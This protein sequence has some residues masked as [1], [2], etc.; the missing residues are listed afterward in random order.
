LFIVVREPKQIAYANVILTAILC[1][2]QK[3][4]T[5]LDN[6]SVP[7]PQVPDDPS[8]HPYFWIV[9]ALLQEVVAVKQVTR[10]DPDQ[11]MISSYMGLSIILDED[12]AA[13]TFVNLISAIITSALRSNRTTP[14]N[15]FL[16]SD[17]SESSVV[18]SLFCKNVPDQ[19][20]DT[21]MILQWGPPDKY[22]VNA[23]SMAFVAGSRRE[24]TFSAR[25]KTCR[26]LMLL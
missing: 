12:D 8:R 14:A 15:N 23:F 2:L 10:D 9:R 11:V 19:I 17:S 25:M 21:Q 6:D 3:F 7:K 1:G 13:Y 16:R 24:V 5:A 18:W 20:N 22:L 4:D 26:M